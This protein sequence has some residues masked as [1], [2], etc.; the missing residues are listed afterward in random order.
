MKLQCLPQDIFSV[1]LS[2]IFL[3]SVLHFISLLSSTLG[4]SE[5]VNK[6]TGR[7]IYFLVQP[8]LLLSPGVI[9]ELPDLMRPGGLW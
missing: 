2:L 3:F 9:L 5:R 7:F 6:T 4:F 8:S 1:T